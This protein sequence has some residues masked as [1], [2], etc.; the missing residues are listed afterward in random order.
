MSI[1][2]TKSLGVKGCALWKLDA[3]GE[4]GEKPNVDNVSIQLPSIELETTSITLMGTLDVPDVSRIGNLQLSATIPL[5]VK[6]AMELCE[7]GKVV[8]W[9]V[10]WASMTYN[11]E[12][13]TTT[14]KAFKV[15]ASGFVTSIPNAEVNAGTENT[16]DVTMN[17]ISISKTNITDNIVEYEIDRG[18]G[19]FKVKGADIISGISSLY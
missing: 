10:T 6:E 11:A 4:A 3:R 12:S 18:K 19:I 2:I 14:P 8:K 13:G 7:L 16:G 9:M 1:A 17:L 15:V 5:D